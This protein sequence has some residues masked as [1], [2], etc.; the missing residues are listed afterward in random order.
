[1]GLLQR[2]VSSGSL[3]LP[4]RTLDRQPSRLSE[5]REPDGP[6]AVPASRTVSDR[7]P[8]GVPAIQE[9]AAAVA[10][11][12][13]SDAEGELSAQPGESSREVARGA[14][15]DGDAGSDSD[16]AMV[17]HLQEQSE[18]PHHA[19]A[20]AGAAGRAR[21]RVSL[22]RR[23]RRVRAW[24]CVLCSRRRR[25]VAARAAVLVDLRL[26]MYRS[27]VG[28]Y[29]PRIY[30]WECV[31]MLQRLLLAVV[32]TVGPSAP[33]IRTSLT[34][35]LCVLL[36]SGHVSGGRDVTP[37]WNPLVGAHSAV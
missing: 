8:P 18:L 16:T 28:M 35:G 22:R 20:A 36:L 33:V 13:D 31:L 3:L 27:L 21:R 7:L 29:R 30:W 12:S 26:G 24:A 9:H 6:G 19:G 32:F 14:D 15:G 10:E 25:G 34:A 5:H 4:W 11:D 23:C 37:V 17:H 2:A 1:M